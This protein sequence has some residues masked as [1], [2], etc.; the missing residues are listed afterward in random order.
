[1]RR[2][3]R[4]FAA[5]VLALGAALFPAAPEACAGVVTIHPDQLI[6]D[7]AAVVTHQ[8]P[9][10]LVGTGDYSSVIKLPVGRSVT[11]IIVTCAGS[12]AGF[13]LSAKLFRKKVGEANDTIISFYPGTI[14][15]TSVHTVASG[16][17]DIDPPAK[18][19]PGYRYFVIV[20][21]ESANGQ[22]YDV[23]VTYQ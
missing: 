8:Y 21:L 9:G 22:I 15:D 11:R 7:V 3:L 10:G 14:T 2:N 5:V 18:V 19:A 23:R 4:I 20:H 13:T 17:G 12:P 1:M 16:P 6:P